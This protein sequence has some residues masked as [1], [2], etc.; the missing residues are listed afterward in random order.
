MPHLYLFPKA[1]APK[2]KNTNI[3][4][5]TGKNIMEQLKNSTHNDTNII[6]IIDDKYIMIYTNNITHTFNEKDKEFW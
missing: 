3:T 1:L 4:E 6:K 2:N 5:G